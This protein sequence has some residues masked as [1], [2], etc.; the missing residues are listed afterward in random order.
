MACVIVASI[1]ATRGL[2]GFFLPLAAR[3]NDATTPWR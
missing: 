3:V 1:G 2:A